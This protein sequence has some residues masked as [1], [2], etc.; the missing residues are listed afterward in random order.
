MGRHVRHRPGEDA[1]VG[2]S[3]MGV[4]EG[5]TQVSGMEG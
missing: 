1:G 4:G 2:E 3:L 5:A